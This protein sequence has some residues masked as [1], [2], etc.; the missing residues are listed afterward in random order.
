MVTCGCGIRIH[1]VAQG[2]LINTLML[3]GCWP[4]V[5]TRFSADHMMEGLVSY[6]ITNVYEIFIGSF[7]VAS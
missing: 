2:A 4:Q 7:T 5:E 1:G 6:S 3:F